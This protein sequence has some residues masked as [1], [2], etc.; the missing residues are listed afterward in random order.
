LPIFQV[1]TPEEIP[2]DEASSKI[3]EAI[4]KKGSANAYFKDSK[5]QVCFLCH[6]HSIAKDALD[7]YDVALNLLKACSEHCCESY[8]FQFSSKNKEIEEKRKSVSLLCLLNTSAASL[9]LGLHSRVIKDCTT[10]LNIEVSE[11]LANSLHPI[12]SRT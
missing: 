4:E 3:Q 7:E 6:F 12:S 9:K 1:E 5:F 11:H 10:V 2:D 8:R